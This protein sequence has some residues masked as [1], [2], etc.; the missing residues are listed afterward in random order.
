MRRYPDLLYCLKLD[1]LGYSFRDGN[2]FSVSPELHD[3][4]GILKGVDLELN[5]DRDF[6]VVQVRVDGKVTHHKGASLP[7]ALCEA[8]IDL[9]QKKI[10]PLS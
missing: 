8:I 1:E 9:K 3:L 5:G 6:F 10:L 2:H 7:N 4:F